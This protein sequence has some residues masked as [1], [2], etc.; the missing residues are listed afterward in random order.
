MS[1]Q[2]CLVAGLDYEGDL[3]WAMTMTWFIPLTQYYYERTIDVWSA[4]NFVGVLA[5][6]N[7]I[8][9][10]HFYTFDPADGSVIRDFNLH[11][12]KLSF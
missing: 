3:V 5:E 6:D 10:A 1:L 9:A 11:I 7:T 8:D 12:S 4:A 2:L